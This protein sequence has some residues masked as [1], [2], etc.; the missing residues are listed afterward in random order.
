MEGKNKKKKQLKYLRMIVFEKEVRWE[1]YRRIL[2]FGNKSQEI[3]W[4]CK[5]SK[6][7]ILM[8]I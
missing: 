3:M 8:K 6:S 1:E 7:L 4:I 2:F 5:L